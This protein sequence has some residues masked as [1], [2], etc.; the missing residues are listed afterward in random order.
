M[1]KILTIA[2][3]AVGYILG[4]RA[5]RE[6]YEQIRDQAQ[7]VWRDPRVQEKTDQAATVIK[8][9]AAPAVKE[10]VSKAAKQVTEKAKSNNSTRES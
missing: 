8:D 4:A 3:G 9:K 2:A 6:R 1:S 10:Q 5:G 7:R